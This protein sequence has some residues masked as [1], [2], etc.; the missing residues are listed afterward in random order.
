[1]EREREGGKVVGFPVDEFGW[2]TRQFMT[3]VIREKFHGEPLKFTSTLLEKPK[4][5]EEHGLTCCCDCR[6]V[7]SC[8]S[9]I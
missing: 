6:H 5:V 8:V 7:N 9:F 4:T 1:M 2:V 3:V